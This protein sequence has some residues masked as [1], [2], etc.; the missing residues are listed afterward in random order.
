M[1]RRS[2]TS[3][4]RLFRQQGIYHHLV[5][6]RKNAPSS[7]LIPVSSPIPNWAVVTRAQSGGTERFEVPLPDHGCHQYHDFQKDRD[8]VMERLLKDPKRFQQIGERE[9]RS[10]SSAAEF[11]SNSDGKYF[12]FHRGMDLMKGCH[13]IVIY[14]CSFLDMSSQQQS[15]KLVLLLVGQLSGWPTC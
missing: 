3:F 13:D 12:I 6:H 15:L 1:L 4:P 10:D 9:D 2:L 11:Q 8:L 5:R 7:V 14:T